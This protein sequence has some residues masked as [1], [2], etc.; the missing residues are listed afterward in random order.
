LNDASFA[1]NF[2]IICSI[3]IVGGGKVIPCDDCFTGTGAGAGALTGFGPAGTGCVG[4]I[5]PAVCAVAPAIKVNPKAK[6][7]AIPNIPQR[8]DCDP[9][10]I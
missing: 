9:N 7:T 4:R 8:A 2:W 3:G 5:G 6:L 10:F 1:A